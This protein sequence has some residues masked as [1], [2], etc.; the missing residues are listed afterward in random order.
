MASRLAL[1]D[2][3]IAYYQSRSWPSY[4]ESD[5]FRNMP[6]TSEM[7]S[8]QSE[9]IRRHSDRARGSHRFGEGN[10]RHQLTTEEARVIRSS[11]AT[12]AELAAEF[13]VDRSQIGKIRRG[14]AWPIDK[15]VKTM[16]I[17]LS[18]TGAKS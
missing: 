3:I 1:L 8:E 5:W 2:S 13:C 11:S 6:F 12:E 17:R 14:K 9:A 15:G 18:H 7:L 4:Q 16:L 10:S